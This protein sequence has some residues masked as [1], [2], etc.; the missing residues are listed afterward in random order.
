MVS[1]YIKT[2]NW[3]EG[4]QRWVKIGYYCKLCHYFQP[5][6]TEFDIQRQQLLEKLESLG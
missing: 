5:V 3:Y 4:K 2:G 6:E 1:A